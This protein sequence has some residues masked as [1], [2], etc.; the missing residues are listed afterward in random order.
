MGSSET[1]VEAEIS[2]EKNK[3]TLTPADSLQYGTEYI[4]HLSDKI[5]DVAGNTLKKSHEWSFTTESLPLI[6]SILP[7]E[8][9]EWVSINTKVIV[10]FNARYRG[11][12]PTFVSITLAHFSETVEATAYGSWG[13][14]SGEAVLTPVNSLQYNTK[15]TVYF[16]CKFSSGEERNYEWS[17]TTE[18]SP[19]ELGGGSLNNV[20]TNRNDEVFITGVWDDDNAYS[21]YF[22][23]KFNNEGSR[24]WFKETQGSVSAIEYVASLNVTNEFVYVLRMDGQLDKYTTSGEEMWSVET[25]VYPKENKGIALSTDGGV[26]FYSNYNER[27]VKLGEQGIISEISTTGYSIMDIEDAGGYLLVFGFEGGPALAKLDYN[28]NWISWGGTMSMY[29]EDVFGSQYI[30]DDAYGMEIENDN[31]FLV[32]KKDNLLTAFCYELSGNSMSYKWQTTYGR[33]YENGMRYDRFG[34]VTTDRNGN[35][36]ALVYARERLWGILDDFYY[37]WEKISPSGEIE[38]I[39]DSFW[40]GK[41]ISACM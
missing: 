36:Y 4:A 37:H 13:S 9:A 8:N 41:Y 23:A 3:V 30:P 2:I 22:T 7:E 19:W 27:I 29:L 38:I 25:S 14:Y 33:S 6:V 18:M 40:A 16:S 21:T 17:F 11:F 34:D 24:Q 1:W 12:T 28:L 5:S 31:L 26:Y 10:E 15:Y 20:K 32:G 39:S 35:F